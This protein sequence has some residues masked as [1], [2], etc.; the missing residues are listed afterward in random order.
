MAAAM[1]INS[2]QLDFNLTH[3][4]KNWPSVFNAIGPVPRLISCHQPLPV[5]EQSFIEG[6]IAA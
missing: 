2:T 4:M 3:A 1:R 6:A 5:F